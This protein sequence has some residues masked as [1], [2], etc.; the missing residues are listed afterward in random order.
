M[1]NANDVLNFLSL[2]KLEVNGL[3]NPNF[4]CLASCINPFTG[5]YLGADGRV[6]T[7]ENFQRASY[8]AAQNFKGLG[9]PSAEV[10]PRIIQLA[11]RFSW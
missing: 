5:L 2:P 1:N 8:V 9:G 10:T 7:W 6:L 4:N 3:P 11:V